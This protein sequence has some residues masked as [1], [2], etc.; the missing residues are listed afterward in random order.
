[1]AESE[2]TLIKQAEMW[3]KMSDLYDRLVNAIKGL[4]HWS[5]R[6]PEDYEKNQRDLESLLASAVREGARRAS[7]QVGNY[8]EGGGSWSKW[9]VPGLVTLTV[10]GIIGNVVQYAEVASLKTAFTDFATSMERRVNNLEQ[11]VYRGSPP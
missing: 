7:I 3:L 1:M 10:A 6:G 8:N 9:I 5:D 11:R 4:S 2:S